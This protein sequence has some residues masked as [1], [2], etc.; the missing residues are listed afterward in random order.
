VAHPA[1]F[2]GKE[3]L[4]LSA[5]WIGLIGT[6]FVIVLMLLRVPVAFSMLVVS[7]VG[8]GVLT[9][10]H[11][12]FHSMIGDLY[13]QF[14]SYS[15]SVVPLFALMG[16]LASYSGVG[17]KLFVMADKFLGHIRGG[18]CL[19]VQMACAIFGAICGSNSATIVT[20]GAVAYPEMKKQGYDDTLATASIA[21]GACLA[22]LIPPSV[23]L[24]VY[25]IA[26]E[27][28]VGKL[29]IAGI[30]PGILLMLLFMLV[31]YILVTRNPALAPVKPRVPWSERMNILL[32]GG[33]LEVLIVFIISI[34]GIFVGAFTATEA[35]A[36]GAGGMMIVCL[37][38]R[39]LSFS[40][41]KKSLLNASKLTAMVFLIVASA[42]VF[43]RFFALS[44]IPTWLGV[45]VAGINMNKWVI[46]AVILFIYLIMGMLIDALAMILLSIPAFY[47]IVVTT[48]GYDP[49]WFGVLIVLVLSMGSIT[50]PIGLNVFVMHGTVKNV[51]LYSIFRG[52]WPYVA[53]IVVCC[54]IMIA[55]PSIATFLPSLF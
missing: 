5:E 48:L 36:V 37:I 19:A 51:P 50:P 14:S 32:H 49:V 35:G 22:S 28:S 1:E 15:L 24:V 16:Y 38:S 21:S 27:V 31:G 34:G 30:L 40:V 54:A 46:F 39:Q 17:S 2:S 52:V 9:S 42:T 44:R 25:G 4:G 11:A 7:V 33:V 29:L 23:V 47:P 12:A 13:R 55:F 10:F 20:M 53:A 43:S 3:F 45:V 26:T 8:M 18:L 6:L 41:L